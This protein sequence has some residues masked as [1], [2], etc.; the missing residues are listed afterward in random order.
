MKKELVILSANLVFK[1]PQNIQEAEERLKALRV[2]IVQL[3]TALRNKHVSHPQTGERLTTKQYFD[4]KRE[5]RSVFSQKVR[6][7]GY[8]K[9]W[10]KLQGGIP[11][12]PDQFNSEA[13]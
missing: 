4:W 13:V 2:D 3:E 7:T 8:L 11:L 5:V 9:S 12:T 6:E 10:M 1:A